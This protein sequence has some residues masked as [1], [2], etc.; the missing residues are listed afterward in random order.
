VDAFVLLPDLLDA[1]PPGENPLVAVREAFCELAAITPADGSHLRAIT[2]ADPALKAELDRVFDALGA[3]LKG[4]LSLR[5]PQD[6]DAATAAEVAVTVGFTL[7][8]LAFRDTVTNTPGSAVSPTRLREY[9]EVLAGPLL[10]SSSAE[11]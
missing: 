6:P 11:T 3:K 2:D 1:R 4:R 7:L 9:F 5:Y 10:T 8:G